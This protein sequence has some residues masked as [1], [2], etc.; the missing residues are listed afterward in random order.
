MKK[1]A[2]TIEASQLIGFLDQELN[3]LPDKRKG[4][5]KKYAVKD[6]VRAAFSVFFTQSPSFLQHQRLMKQKKGQDNAKSLFGLEEIPCDNQIRNLLD[7]ISA[8]TVF[9]TFK[10]VF[11]WL[12][13]NPII[14]QFKYLDNQILLSLD[15][16]EYYSSKK[17]NCPH[18]NPREHR[19]GS[20]TYYHQVITPVIVS[21]QKK[22][23]INLE[24]EFIRKQD[25][26]TKQDCENAAVKRWLLRNPVDQYKNQITLLGD[27]LYSRQPICKLALNQGYSFIFVALPSSH[28][29]LYKWID[30][31]EK[32]GELR[33]GETKKYEKGKERLYRYRYVN[34]WPIRDSEPS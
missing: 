16:T 21:P 3:Q 6:A 28:K 27:D 17:I 30:F 33:T 20:T 25:G 14:N 5:N 32:N 13:K 24:P 22:Q 23:V 11:E 7:P 1:K 15:G 2:V 26:K 31:S 29:S 10:T 19:N 4:D 34:N 9:G 12:D 8:K 18:C